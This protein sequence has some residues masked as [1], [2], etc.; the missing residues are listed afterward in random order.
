MVL[1]VIIASIANNLK[2][3]KE[4]LQ[5][6]ANNL[7]KIRNEKGLSQDDLA[8]SDEISRSMISLVETVKTDLTVSKV[9]LIADALG[10]PPKTLF[11]FE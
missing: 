9:K 11:D 10:V 3:N 8:V 4:Y 7:K 1:V 5:K 2:M 6:F